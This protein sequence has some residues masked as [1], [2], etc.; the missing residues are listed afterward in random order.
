[1][2]EPGINPKNKQAVEAFIQKGGKLKVG[3]EVLVGLQKWETLV[4][5]PKEVVD[6]LLGNMSEELSAAEGYE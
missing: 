3:A 1:M 5:K 2:M 6:K 4:P